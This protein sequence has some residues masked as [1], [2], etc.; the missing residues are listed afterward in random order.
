MQSVSTLS[1]RF[2]FGRPTTGNCV[3]VMIDGKD[4][5]EQMYDRIS[6]AEKS[7]LIANYDLDPGLKFARS[8]PGAEPSRPI[9]SACRAPI[10]DARIDPDSRT[11][12]LK[13]LL[14]KK[15]RQGVDVKVLVWQPR[16]ALRI[17]PGADERGI[18]SREGDVEELGRIARK[19]GVPERLQV[20]VDST[21]PTMTSAH[22][23][24]IVVIDGCVGF[25]G[26]LDL[27]RGKWDV[28]THDYESS[29]RD[30]D[31]EPWHD[32][33]SMV[34]GPAVWDL[35]CHFWQRWFYAETKDREK[36]QQLVAL[37]AVEEAGDTP[38][39]ALRTWKEMDRS[40]G[41]GAWYSEIF[42]KAEKG[43]YIENQ[44]PFQTKALTRILARRLRE[45]RDL[46]V[47]IVG[48]ME[49]NLPGFV[50]SMIAKMSV[51]DV[52]RNLALLRKASGGRLLTFSL[53]SQHKTVPALRRQ[54]YV[55]S[56][57]MIA[58]DRW[59]T[60]GSA[61]LDKNGLADSTELNLGITSDEL[62]A[63][64]RLRLWQE[65]T[66]GMPRARLGD[67]AEGFEALKR[68]AEENG[69]RVAQGRPIAGSIYFYNF[70]EEGLPPPYP[71]AGNGK[72]GLL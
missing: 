45:A 14:V 61:N 70:E 17:L 30:P 4:A 10:A 67:F 42:R 69:E 68:L 12:T 25:C 50:G 58:D 64:T 56:K 13:D 60:L 39:T 40:G 41:I 43:I 7:V 38:V 9:K 15:A 26:G 65:H 18:N 36:A 29:L 28:S 71:G 51:K 5:F 32:V 16:L 8:Y 47:I 6:R 48:P 3:A 63:K 72:S 44:F 31:S 20:R 52:D 24:K 33:H 53:V 11:C 55:H 34:K 35:A 19:L 27:S 62:A 57:L 66:G 2:R 22:H 59:M 46:L 54:I 37:A 1:T 23:E 49:P 21:A